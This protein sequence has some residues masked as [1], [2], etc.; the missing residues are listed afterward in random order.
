LDAAIALFREHGFEGSSAQMLV[1]TLG[2]GRQSLYDTFG[3]KWQLYLAALRRY[4]M[5]EAQAHRSALKSGQRAIDG[6]VAMI[7]RVVADA[8]K[9]CLGVNSICEFGQTRPELVQIQK[10]A[11][12]IILAAIKERVVEAQAEGSVDAELDPDQIARF[13]SASFAGIRIAV[14]GGASQGEAQALGL[15][16]LRALR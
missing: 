9:S 7:E 8:R 13:L 3:D 11:S 2:I 12:R 6:I 14:R 10:A 15:M 4:T 5:S 1:S 16:A